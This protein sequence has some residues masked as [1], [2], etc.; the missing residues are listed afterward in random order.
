RCRL[1]EATDSSL[2]TAGAA[3]VDGR[4]LRSC[5]IRGAMKNGAAWISGEATLEHEN[6]VIKGVEVDGEKLESDLVIATNGAWMNQLLHPFSLDLRFHVQT[7]EVLH[8]QTYQLDTSDLPVVNPPNNQYLLSFPD[9][10]I[11]AGATHES[12][13]TL[14]PV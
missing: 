13:K 9:G 11:V 7:G 6:N 5:L 4:Q 2:Y 10:K 1:L 8:M 12:A 14:T 3:G